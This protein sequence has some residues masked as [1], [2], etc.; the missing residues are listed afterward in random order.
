MSKAQ[1]EA[2]VCSRSPHEEPSGPLAS[3]TLTSGS[4]PEACT[5]R[6]RLLNRTLSG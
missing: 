5:A 3:K 6:E 1:P 2:T 4:T